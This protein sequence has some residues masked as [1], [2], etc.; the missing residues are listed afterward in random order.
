MRTGPA[1]LSPPRSFTQNLGRHRPTVALLLA[2]IMTGAVYSASGA[3]SSRVRA[4][5]V[6]APGAGGAS[7]SMQTVLA[8]FPVWVRGEGYTPENID[9]SVV[10]TVAHFSVV[11]SADASVSPYAGGRFPDPTLVSTAHAAG[12]RVVLVL[13]DDQASTAAAFSAVVADAGRRGTLV[14]NMMSLVV[15]LGYDGINLDWEFPKTPADGSGLTALVHELRT[16]LGP[17]RSLSLAAASSDFDAHYVDIPAI[18]GDLDWLC[19]MTYLYSGPVWSSK[20]ANNAP[21]YSTPDQAASMD[22][23]VAYYLRRG[24]TPSKLLVGLPFF[25]ERFDGAQDLYQSLSNKAGGDIEYRAIRD[26]IGNGWSA[27]RD[28][29]AR[30]PYLVRTDGTAGVISYDDPVSIDA[31]CR[32]VN[33]QQ[34]GGVVIWRLGQDGIGPP[35]SQPLLESARSCR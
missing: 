25:G 14:A 26:L 6:P 12:A 10:T 17:T 18:I 34:L 11:P 13:G 7:P 22:D 2:F 30:V 23:T 16:A 19:A 31:K 32:Y 35:A 3:K 20:A 28:D 8:Y 4:D 5:I 29:L 21:L 1:A 15:G 9:F 33:A 24:A 27:H